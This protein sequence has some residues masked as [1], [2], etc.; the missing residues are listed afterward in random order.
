MRRLQRRAG[1][2]SGCEN[3]IAEW[4]DALIVGDW[5]S[6]K[7][8]LADTELRQTLERHAAAIRKQLLAKLG[9]LERPA[10]TR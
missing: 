1:S 4:L 7:S 5:D 8:T 2:A 10:H 3:E 6:E 9:S